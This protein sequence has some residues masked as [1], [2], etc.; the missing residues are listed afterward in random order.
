MKSGDRSLMVDR[1]V[2]PA[3]QG[4]S[5]SLRIPCRTSQ[6]PHSKSRSH[7]V[8]ITD[9][10]NVEVPHDLEA[11]RVAVALG[12]Y[13]S[14]IPLVDK[15]VPALHEWLRRQ[16]RLDPPPLSFNEGL[17]TWR[18]SK[19]EDCCPSAGF[20]EA[21]AAA[22]HWRSIPHIATSIGAP[23]RQLGSLVAA[24][25]A[26]HEP[27]GTL[28]PEQQHIDRAASA[29]LRGVPA[30]AWLWDA[31]IHPCLVWQ[32]H[33]D[34]R[35][36]SPLSARF[37]LGAICNHVD[38]DWLALTLTGRDLDSSAPDAAVADEGRSMHP[39]P[40]SSWLAWTAAPWDVA[41]PSARAQWLDAGVNRST[42]LLLGGA[43][44]RP[45]EVT[46]L[47]RLLG[48]TVDGTARI[49]A[50]WVQAGARPSTASLAALRNLGHPTLQAPSGAALDRL[51]R[52]RGPERPA[53]TRTQ[54]ALLLAEHGTAP[55]AIAA[56]RAG[57]LPC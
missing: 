21:A 19:S 56:M 18:L 17:Q 2:G 53:F 16:A 10:W 7:R 5:L 27:A 51:R 38:V 37:Y 36:A 50:S 13:L 40:L 22:I 23:S 35:S 30:V 43:R 34:V 49:I 26:A 11:E 20:N 31:G 46:D 3:P 39:E 55:D 54:L 48:R 57:V 42:I 15:T 1:T 33:T 12:G 4:T 25:R 44:Y 32:V 28:V 14:C 41:D 6:S 47:A 45:E 9:D 52:M 24:S 8:L 29:C